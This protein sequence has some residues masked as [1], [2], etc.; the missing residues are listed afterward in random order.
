MEPAKHREL[1]GQSN[2]L[3]LGNLKKVLS[4]K[5]AQEV[6]IRIPVVP[7]CNDSAENIRETA[8]FAVGLGFTQAELIPYHRLGVSKYA[9]Y[10]MVYPLAGCQPAP[11]DH[12]DELK[13][14]VK[15]AGLTEMAGSI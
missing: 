11:E 2:Y 3:V 13:K 15:E 12:L 10:G 5:G 8:R 6:I 14:I 4:V 1:T 9:Q 7:G